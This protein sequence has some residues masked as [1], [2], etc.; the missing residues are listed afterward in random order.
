MLPRVSRS[1][2]PVIAGAAAAA[3]SLAVLPGCGGGAH[4]AAALT[5]VPA[6]TT[7]E[8]PTTSTTAPAPLATVAQSDVANLAVYAQPGD[9]T[10]AQHLSNPRPLGGPLVLLVTD[11]RP[12][13][14]QALLPVRPNGSRGWVAA[15]DVTLSSHP[16]RIVVELGAHRMTV[17]DGYAKVAVDSIG[18]GTQATPTPGGLYYTEDFVQL[19]DPNGPYGAYA[20][21]L[22]GFSEV[23]TSF[24]GGPGQ[25]AIHGTNEPDKLGSDVSHGCI[26][27]SNPDIIKLA[28]ILP[29]GV[30]V[31]VVA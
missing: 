19:D 4:H 13:W 30:P 18:V 7:T 14:V 6:P 31:Q 26:R 10:P 16:Y 24:G 3:I 5:P 28:G 2:L 29:L 9:P 11:Q 22:S 23:L 20:Y 15:G 1:R 12:G 25:L 21:G 8:A 17:Y 27:L